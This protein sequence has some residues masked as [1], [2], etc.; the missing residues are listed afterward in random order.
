MNRD[1][2]GLGTVE[3]LLKLVIVISILVIIGIILGGFI[4]WIG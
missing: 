2:G 3:E 1:I 4:V